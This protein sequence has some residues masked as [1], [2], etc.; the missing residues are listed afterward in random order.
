METPS[1]TSVLQ[2]FIRIYMEDHYK[3]LTPEQLKQEAERLRE[4]LNKNAAG[5]VCDRSREEYDALYARID[6]YFKE[7]KE[8]D[9]LFRPRI[10]KSAAEG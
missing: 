1:E 5:R 8:W 7:K 3:P 4:H 6:A 10:R 2:E 9:K